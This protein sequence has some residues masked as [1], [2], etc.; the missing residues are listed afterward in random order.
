M[1]SL[2]VDGFH[3]LPIKLLFMTCMVRTPYASLPSYKLPTCEGL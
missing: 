3:A 2:D 1:G